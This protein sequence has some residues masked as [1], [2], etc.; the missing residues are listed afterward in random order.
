MFEQTNLP[1]P[2]SAIVDWILRA[3]IAAAFVLFGMDK[4]PA[5]LQSE[6]VK[7]FQQIGAGQWFR[8]FT[9]VVEVLGGLLVLV[10]RTANLGLALLAS[11]MASAVFILTL[12]LGRPA[13]CI[14]SGGFLIGLVAFWLSRRNK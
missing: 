6:W 11:I 8:Y 9:G 3:V 12:V 14:V 4:F 10:P 2:K 13:D 1:E 7:L 5:G